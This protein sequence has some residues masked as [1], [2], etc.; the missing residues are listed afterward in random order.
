MDGALGP[1]GTDR[2][3]D[4][5]F[6]FANVRRSGQE[7]NL[8]NYFLAAD[9]RIQARLEFVK[10]FSVYGGIEI[11]WL[12]AEHNGPAYL[13]EQYRIAAGVKA[14][15]RVAGFKNFPVSKAG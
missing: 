2:L 3:F 9:A 8:T 4:A 12:R 6:S 5:M 15:P 13:S 11:I 1:E 10:I 14:S 7:I